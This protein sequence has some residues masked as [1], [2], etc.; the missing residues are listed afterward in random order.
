[1]YRKMMAVIVYAIYAMLCLH[2]PSSHV[3]LQKVS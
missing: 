2:D 1:M 3:E